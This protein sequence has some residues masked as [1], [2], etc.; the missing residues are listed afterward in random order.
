LPLLLRLASK[1]SSLE[2]VTKQLLRQLMLL[3][4]V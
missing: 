3:V 2:E 4:K 1:V